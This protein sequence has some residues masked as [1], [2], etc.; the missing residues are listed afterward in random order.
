MSDDELEL[1]FAQLRA[2]VHG[3]V[4]LVSAA[5]PLSSRPIQFI[6]RDATQCWMCWCTVLKAPYYAHDSKRS[7]TLLNTMPPKRTRAAAGARGGAVNNGKYLCVAEKPS[8]AKSVA[9]I[10]SGG[11]FNNRAGKDK[12]CRNFDLI[13]QFPN[14]GPA[15]EMTITSVRGHLTS[16]DFDPAMKGWKSCDPVQLFEAQIFTQVSKASSTRHLLANSSC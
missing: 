1:A 7:S 14:G 4:T 11:S 12:F 16:S 15:V 9:E 10:L 13:Y 6:R 5:H 2:N 8:I 3:P